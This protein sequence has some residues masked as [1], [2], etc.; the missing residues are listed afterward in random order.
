MWGGGC[1]PWISEANVDQQLALPRAGLMMQSQL[2]TPLPTLA[3]GVVAPQV[4]L[5]EKRY[6]GLSGPL[7][8][9]TS[10]P[11]PPPDYQPLLAQSEK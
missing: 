8:T 6:R 11:P 2:S 9:S 10:V 4:G 7:L 5:G 3:A 1:H